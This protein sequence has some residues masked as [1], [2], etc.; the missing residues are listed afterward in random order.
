M[1]GPRNDSWFFI[2]NLVLDCQLLLFLLRE[3]E[4][5]RNRI[6]ELTSGGFIPPQSEIESYSYEVD[7]QKYVSLPVSIN[8]LYD[9]LDMH[10]SSIQ[11]PASG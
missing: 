9:L 6:D 5:E 4:L 8:L 1:E 3:E 2:I 7:V 10:I 11:D